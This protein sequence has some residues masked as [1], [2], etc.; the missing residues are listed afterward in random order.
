MWPHVLLIW[1]QQNSL[2][3]VVLEI[4]LSTLLS[5]SFPREIL[6]AWDL[7]SENY[8]KIWNIK[9]WELPFALTSGVL[10]FILSHNILK[11]AYIFQIATKYLAKILDL[12]KLVDVMRLVPEAC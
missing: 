2:T 10:I 5:T 1:Q 4:S 8:L 3:V 12:I 7:Y 11:S 6:E 9:S